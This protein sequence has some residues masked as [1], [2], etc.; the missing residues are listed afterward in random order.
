M[1][2]VTTCEI[3]IVA[4]GGTLIRRCTKSTVYRLPANG[5]FYFIKQRT[6]RY[7]NAESAPNGNMA[8][9]IVLGA[10]HMEALEEVGTAIRTA[11]AQGFDLPSPTQVFELF[12]WSRKAI[13]ERK[14]AQC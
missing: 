11:L 5:S 2:R 13:K 10:V 9:S 12:L 8:R 4:M 7:H 14:L 3:A 1:S 6:V